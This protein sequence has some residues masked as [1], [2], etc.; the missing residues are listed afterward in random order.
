MMTSEARREAARKWKEK[1]AR[2]GVFAVRCKVTGA[3]WVGSSR[4]VDSTRNQLWFAL[5]HAAHRDPAMQQEWDRNGAEA[6]EYEVLATLD[7]DVL[8]LLVADQLKEWKRMWMERLG[9]RPG[10]A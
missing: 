2:A 7:E 4:N 1:K 6:F 8:P 10:L 3:V 5:R 9:A